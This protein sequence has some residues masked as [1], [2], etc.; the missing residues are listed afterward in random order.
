MTSIKMDVLKRFRKTGA[1]LL[2]GKSFTTVPDIV[3]GIYELEFDDL[4]FRDSQPITKVTLNNN[5]LK[6]LAGG[7]ANFKGLKELVLSQNKVAKLTPKLWELTSLRVLLLDYNELTAVPPEIEALKELKT[8]HLAHNHITALGPLHLEHLTELTLGANQITAIAPDAFALPNLTSLDLNKN[9]ITELPK[10]LFAA[11]VNVRLVDLSNNKLQVAQGWDLSKCSKLE[12]LRIEANSLTTFDIELGEN[13]PI[14]TLQLG[15]NTLTDFPSCILKITGLTSLSLNN[16]KIAHV[17][18][19]ISDLSKLRMLAIQNNDIARLPLQLGQIPTLKTLNARANL[20]KTIPLAKVEAGNEVLIDH[21][22][23]QVAGAADNNAAIKS[24]GAARLDI[25]SDGKVDAR[26]KNL[27]TLSAEN[28]GAPERVT[29]LDASANPLTEMLDLTSFKGLLTLDLSSTKITVLHASL[30]ASHLQTLKLGSNALTNIDALQE[31][32][33]L[34]S[35]DLSYSRSLPPFASDKCLPQSLTHVS[36]ES[37]GLKDIPPCIYNLHGLTELVLAR[38][39]IKELPGEEMV[40]CFPKLSKLDIGLNDIRKLPAELS[41][42]KLSA[43]VLEGNPL[44]VPS[45]AIAA[46]GTTA[47]MQYLASRLGQPDA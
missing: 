23:K 7:I 4:S 44:V 27:T 31:C 37:C 46:K 35:L 38:N 8:L 24:S 10:E 34:K 40:V 3:W 16:N 15:F 13:S 32:A 36:L 1:V 39:Q 26:K 29:S 28:F 18:D 22:K 17:P 12:E 6:E 47:V 41:K 19:N 20:I 45:K 25:G 21:L 33:H 2:P 42:L 9:K 11:L 5:E 14:K 43:I 30:T